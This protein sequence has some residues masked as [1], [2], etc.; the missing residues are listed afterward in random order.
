M[1]PL[2]VRNL[3]V[4]DLFLPGA[5]RISDARSLRPRRDT[6]DRH[7]PQ[8]SGCREDLSVLFS[9]ARF[10]NSRVLFDCARF[11]HEW[12]A[13]DDAEF[14]GG[15]VSF[16]ET[17]VPR[18]VSFHRA[19]FSGCQADFSKV[20]FHLLDFTA[21]ELSDQVGFDY[22]WFT[23]GSRVS[24]AGARFSGRRR[25]PVN[26]PEDSRGVFFHRATFAGDVS[27]ARAQF[28]GRVSFASADFTGCRMFAFGGAE[29][30]GG[31]V[32]FVT[33][34]GSAPTGLVP[35]NGPPLPGIRLPPDW[36]S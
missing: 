36:S 35:E 29:F 9:H 5:S 4:A 18:R 27:F 26:D 28:S 7:P 23:S 33:A 34:R 21:A 12:L 13:F 10:S 30:S 32:D 14:S 16:I 31:I 3:I 6:A 25:L 20:D 8:P 22:S 2:V 24:F 15:Q 19:R 17:E 11:T 1:E